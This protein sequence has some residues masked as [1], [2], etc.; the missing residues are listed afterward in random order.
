MKNNRYLILIGILI[1]LVL[2]FLFFN[3][4]NNNDISLNGEDVVIEEDR[5]TEEEFTEVRRIFGEVKENFRKIVER[6][7][8]LD[9][10]IIA[11]LEE[12]IFEIQKL[13]NKVDEELESPN[14]SRKN[15]IENLLLIQE[16]ITQLGEKIPENEE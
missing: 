9:S 11:S 12:D 3:M 6:I 14:A 2:G 13:L 1:A 15:M 4:T 7:L 10:D 16:K 5:I 8:H